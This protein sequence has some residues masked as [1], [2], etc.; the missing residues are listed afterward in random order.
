MTGPE[1]EGSADDRWW[2]TIWCAFLVIAMIGC[3]EFSETRP[4]AF[5]AGIVFVPAQRFFDLS[6]SCWVKYYRQR[7][8]V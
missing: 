2:S 3:W 6:L 7:K 4:M 5:A 1:W 8:R